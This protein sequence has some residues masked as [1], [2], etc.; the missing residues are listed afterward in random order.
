MNLSESELLNFARSLVIF[1]ALTA[2]VILAILAPLKE[3]AEKITKSSAQEEIGGRTIES[4]K[5]E[6][7]SA[8]RA[9]KRFL[10]WDSLALVP[11]YSGLLI[12][13]SFLLAAKNTAWAPTAAKFLIAF[14]LFA[15]ASDWIENYLLYL[16]AGD[17]SEDSR[18]VWWA[19]RLKWLW[20]FVAA[21]TA[22]LIFLRFDSWATATV[23]MVIASI[24]GVSLIAFSSIGDRK[25]E[26]Y[27]NFISGAFGLQLL[28]LGVFGCLMLLCQRYRIGFLDGY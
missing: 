27:L 15:A 13:A 6:I 21:G 20:L 28:I 25:I 18:L 11:L 1:F 8:R 19:E 17:G 9:K 23:L 24:A 26:P 2:V 5:E 3:A 14:T 16:A 12:A 22:S 7:N 10:L 4:S